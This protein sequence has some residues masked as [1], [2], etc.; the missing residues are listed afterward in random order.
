MV[1]ASEPSMPAPAG[2]SYVGILL[3]AG[4]GARFRAS[5][6]DAGA[7]KLLSTLPD[8]RPVV[9]AAAQALGAVASR[10]LVVSRPGRDALREA[11]SHL[12]ACEVIEAPEARRGMGASIAAAARH[13]LHAPDMRTGAAA[14]HG[15][16]V[17]LGDMPW[18]ARATLRALCAEGARHA[19]VAPSCEGRHGHP[20]VFAWRLLAELAELD[21]DT[22]ARML[23]QRHGVHMLPCDDAGVL[24]D[25]DVVTDLA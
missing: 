23:L 21:G 4:E 10:L 5:A 1:T 18:I 2:P 8:G 20:V 24:R 16:L 3:A 12:P 14:P 17:A 22:G 19:I 11:L 15:V 13:L 9:L 7:D 6:G 25:V